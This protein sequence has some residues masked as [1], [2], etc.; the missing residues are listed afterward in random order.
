MDPRRYRRGVPPFGNTLAFLLGSVLFIVI[1]GPSVLFV[2][3]RALAHDRRVAVASAVG[4]A[5]GMLFLIVAAA[6]GLGQLA[7]HSAVVFTAIKLVGAAYLVYLGVRTF[8]SRGELLLTALG[9][10]DPATDRHALAQGVVVG[11]TNPK[12]IAFFAA[13]LPQFVDTTTAGPTTQMLVLGLLFVLL[14]SGL[15]SLWAVAA[16]TASSWIA[17]SPRQLSVFRGAGGLMM[18]LMGVDLAVSGRRV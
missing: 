15:D 17:S 6:F 10:P 9:G 4:N 8:R 2:I 7:E 13:V 5:I 11:V 3:G 1:P 12:A 18:I 14:A 16:G